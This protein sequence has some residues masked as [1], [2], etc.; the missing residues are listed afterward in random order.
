MAGADIF[1]YYA[2]PE[3]A[4]EARIFAGSM[5]D[6]S[7][8]TIQ[9]AMAALDIEGVSTV[10]DI[11]GADGQFV[12]ELM[13]ANPGLRGQV[14][15]LPHAVGGARAEAAKR[16]LCDRFSAVAG[17]FFAQVP[18]ADLYLIKT[19]L[20]DWADGQAVTILRNCRAAA[21][22]GGRAVVVETVVGDPGTP[23]G[24]YGLALQAA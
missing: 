16:G 13:A 19:V 17:D 7:A 2:R 10:V 8:L 23:G 21:P 9:G 15:D 18:A 6:V 24:Y 5:A 3:N 22:A 14:L 11:G 20:H 1:D 12:L 4:K